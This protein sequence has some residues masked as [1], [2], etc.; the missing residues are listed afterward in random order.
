MK[1]ALLLFLLICSIS[2][3]SSQQLEGPA[4]A[5]VVPGAEVVRY[6]EHTKQLQYIRFGADGPA[7]LEEFLSRRQPWMPEVNGGVSWREKSSFKDRLG[8]RHRRMQMLVEGLPVEGA[9]LVVHESGGRLVALNGDLYGVQVKGVEPRL[10]AEEAMARALDHF[11]A[12]RYMWENGGMK[13]R[14]D[15]SRL[16]YLPQPEL[17][18]GPVGQQLRSNHFRL[19]W[20]M[21]VYAMEPLRREWVF[22]D[23]MTGEVM[24]TMNRIHTADVVGSAQTYYSGLRTITTDQ[25]GPNSFRLRE[26]GRGGGLETWNLLAQTDYQFATDFTD[27]DNFWN[28]ANPQLDEFATDAHWGTESTFDY[29]HSQHGWSSYDGNNAP[30]IS[31][32]HYAYRYGNAFWDG[33]T[34]TYG[35]G[36]SVYFSSPLTTLDICGHEF[37]HG[38]TEN[39]AGLLYWE[40]AGGL[41]EGFSDI[42]GKAVEHYARPSQTSWLLSPECTFGQGI[43][44]MAD[45][46][47]FNNPSCYQGQYWSVGLDPHYSSGVPNKWFYILVVGESGTNDLGNAYNVTGLGYAK[48][49]AIAFRTLT[50]YLTPGSQFADARFYAIQSAADLYG[51]CSPEVIATTNAWYAVGVGGPWNPVAQAAFSVHPRNHCTVPATVTFTNSSNGVGTYFWD[52]GDGNSSTAANPTHTYGS[53]GTYTVKLVV[54]HCAGGADSLVLNQCV[55]VDTNQTCALTMPVIGQTF[56]DDCRGRV[57]DPGGDGLYMD[58]CTTIV[59]IAPP[60]ADTVKLHFNEFALQDNEDFMWIFD[61]PSISSPLIGKYTGGTLPNGGTIVSTT[62]AITVRFMSDWYFTYPGFDFDYEC[63]MSTLPPAANF[64]AASFISCDGTVEFEDISGHFPTSWEWDFGDGGTSTQEDPVHQ[65]AQPGSYTVKLRCCNQN[66][67]DSLTLSNVVIYNPNAQVCEVT[68]LP[69]QGN[70]VVTG[71]AGTLMDDGGT[72]NYSLNTITSVTIAPSGA[73]TVELKFT[74]FDLELGFDFVRVYNGMSTQSPMIGNYTGGTLPI[75]GQAFVGT[76]GALTVEL[77]SNATNAAGGFEAVWNAFGATGGPTAQFAAPTTANVGQVLNFT[78]QSIGAT[79]WNWNFGDGAMSFLQNPSHAFASSGV[80]Q[81]VL[82]V[83]NSDGCAHEYSQNVYVGIVGTDP[84]AAIVLDLWPNPAR[85]RVQL[86][87]RLPMESPVR[88]RLMNAL[89]QQVWV[90]EL[91]ETSRLERV[92][93]VSAFA[94]GVYFLRVETDNGVVTRKIALN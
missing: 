63:V 92:L 78:D 44:S 64:T 39:T 26:S 24:C 69:A 37:T 16:R 17:V 88:L 29:Y 94:K 18:W 19:A 77:R 11:K 9:V 53:Q 67:C 72:S 31:Y 43:R 20:K 91:A 87:L 15:A 3:C 50:T 8:V 36:D 22:V 4:A 81:V 52:F 68:E 83:T 61:G 35:D 76:S 14:F 48:A 62:G 54:S 45:P 82:R 41:N 73:N 84:T 42:F 46:K 10:K 34:M 60:G 38:V 21:D 7:S 59:V 25:T 32:V 5:L 40:E 58:N 12:D 89:G 47:V 1:K 6:S 71:C 86:D 13:T 49:E 70:V 74:Q 93:D 90:E 65:Y 51:Y 27:S 33:Q 23:A 28:N 56:L 85:D 2:V 30:M 75:N 80:Y 66:G 55:V 57:L 79:S